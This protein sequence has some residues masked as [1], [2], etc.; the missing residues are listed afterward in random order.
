MKKVFSESEVAHRWA[1]QLQYEAR[2][3]GGNF[4]FDGDT[5]YSY[6]RHFPIAVHHKG[7]VL[8]TINTY[9]NATSKHIREVR[10]AVSHKDKVYCLNPYE[11]HINNHHNNIEYNTYRLNQVAKCKEAGKIHGR[12]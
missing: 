11:A 4:Y 7:A 12:N 8:F 2:N 10:S 3:K 6:G 9:S 5:I 1:N